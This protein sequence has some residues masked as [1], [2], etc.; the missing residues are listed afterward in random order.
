MSIMQM[1][2]HADFKTTER[3]IDLAGVVFADQVRLQSDW[4]AGG[5]T[6]KRYEMKRSTCLNPAR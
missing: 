6:K 5:G 3:Y 4:Y 2:G 1:A